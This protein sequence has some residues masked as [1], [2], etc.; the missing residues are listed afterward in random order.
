MVV[1][2]T[3]SGGKNHPVSQISINNTKNFLTWHCEQNLWLISKCIGMIFV[4]YEQNSAQSLA[5]CGKL[6]YNASVV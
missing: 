1:K 5:I 4:Q 2:T 6:W 3:F